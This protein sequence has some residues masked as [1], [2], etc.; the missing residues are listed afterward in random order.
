VIKG[1]IVKNGL[2]RLSVIIGSALAYGCSGSSNKEIQ[3]KLDEETGRLLSL[4]AEVDALKTLQGDLRER[5]D[6]MQLMQSID[7][8]AYLTPGADGFQTIKTGIGYV[9]ASLEDVK[10][11]ANGSKVTVRFGNPTNAELSSIKFKV[12]WGGVEKDGTPNQPT[13]RAREVSIIKDFKPGSWTSSE[14]TLEGIA[15]TEL[16]FVRIREFSAG[17]IQLYTY[18]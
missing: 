6:G 4:Q 7:R 12:E 11:Y 13:V 17:S 18:R 9:T 2:I 8:I 14:L 10:P 15:P 16:G 5:L 1:I 3:S